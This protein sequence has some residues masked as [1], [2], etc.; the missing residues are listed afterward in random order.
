VH[1]FD[2]AFEPRRAALE[3]RAAGRSDAVRRGFER[4]GVAACEIVREDLLAF[5]QK[6]EREG[7]AARDDAEQRK[8]RTALNLS[9]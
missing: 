5:A 3:Q 2:H 6:I 9:R 8:T 4:L 1:A 7:P